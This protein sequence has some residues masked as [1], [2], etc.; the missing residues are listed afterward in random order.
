VPSSL[1]R[2]RLDFLHHL[3]DPVHIDRYTKQPDM[4]SPALNDRFSI[5]LH[6]LSQ[7]LRRLHLRVVADETLFWPDAKHF[8]S[9]TTL[10][11]LVVMFY[12]VSPSK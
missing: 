10:E 1:R 8:S 11:S 6:H 2:V 9:W 3:Y 7:Y 12:I 5:S 4:V